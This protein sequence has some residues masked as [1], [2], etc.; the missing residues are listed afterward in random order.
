MN[1]SDP[2]DHVLAAIASLLDQ[3][4]SRS[5]PENPV[6][7]DTPAGP[8]RSGAEGYCKFGPGPIAAIRF[9]WSVRREPNGNCYVDETIGESSAPVIAG[10]MSEDEAIKFVDDRESNA[11]LRFETIRREMRG[12]AGARV[13]EIAEDI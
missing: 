11:R 7:D 9:K 2:T 6:P 1:Q 3:P 5:A 12:G 4:E 13:S 10:P 8:E